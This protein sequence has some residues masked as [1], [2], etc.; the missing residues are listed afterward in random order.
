VAL[1]QFLAVGLGADFGF[2]VGQLNYYKLINGI[3]ECL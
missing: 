3:S 2:R 1:L